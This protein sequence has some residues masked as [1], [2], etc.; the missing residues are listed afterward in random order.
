[1]N[2]GE[3]RFYREA[4]VQRVSN[5]KKSERLIA[6]FSDTLVI[7]KISTKAVKYQLEYAIDLE[8]ISMKPENKT[9]NSKIFED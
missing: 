9:G 8:E 3:R 1:L 2:F 4:L 7:C 6:L 5:G